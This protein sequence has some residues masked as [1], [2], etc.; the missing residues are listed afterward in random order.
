M[1]DGPPASSGNTMELFGKERT[2]ANAIGL[3]LGALSVGAIAY[4][5]LPIVATIVWNVVSI[6]AASGILATMWFAWPYFMQLMQFVFYTGFRVA[7]RR[8]IGFD[9]Q[10]A[11]DYSLGK[12]DAKIGSVESYFH[13]LIAAIDSTKEEIKSEEREKAEAE[14]TVRS[15]A[16]RST[17]DDQYTRVSRFNARKMIRSDEAIADMAT[18]VTKMEGAKRVI[19]KML[20]E[21]R[22]ERD[23]TEDEMRHLLLKHKLASTAGAAL[24]EAMSLANDPETRLMLQDIAGEIERRVG[25]KLGAITAVLDGTN[26]LETQIDVRNVVAQA[27]AMDMILSREAQMDAI[28]AGRSA[29][30]QLADNQKTL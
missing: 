10:A 4:A 2:A 16:S 8:I 24:Q 5:V 18:M 11:V 22:F 15:L 30:P 3:G 23:D 26:T 21:L 12:I 28:S 13:K 29:S 6:A 7:W 19:G 17:L 25:E 27:R 20:E 1:S 9:F 14:A